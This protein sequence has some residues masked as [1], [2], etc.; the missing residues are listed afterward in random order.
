MRVPVAPHP[1]Q[2]L[3]MPVFWILAILRVIQWYLIVLIC[4]SLVR[5]D[6][7]HLFMCLFA[8]CV[9]SLLRYLFRSLA[10]FQLDCLFSY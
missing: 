10:H 8:I 2:H 9:S 3:V 6:G 7:K 5:Y 4:T 1:H